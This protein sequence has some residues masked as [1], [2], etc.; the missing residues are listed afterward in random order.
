MMVLPLHW[1][2][3]LKKTAWGSQNALCGMADTQ[4]DTQNDENYCK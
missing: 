3:W 2:A 4:I 1:L